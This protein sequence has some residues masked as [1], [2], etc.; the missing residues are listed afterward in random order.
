MR[1]VHIDDVLVIQIQGTDKGLA[2]LRQEM[3]WAAEKCHGAADW[4]S[5]GKTAD[6]LVDHSLEN[7]C[8]KIFPGSTLVDER[9]D[10]GF[11]ENAAAGCNRV[12]HLVIFG[13]FVQTGCI[14]L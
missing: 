5:A 12:D 9:L 6:G 10:I 14:R 1:V 11:C 3:Q 2:Q 13:I 8:G 7:G 4:F